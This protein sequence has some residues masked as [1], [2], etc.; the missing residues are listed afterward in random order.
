MPRTVNVHEAKTSLSRLLD[1]VAR[2][3]SV[4]IARAGKPVA[5]L[6]PLRR[7]DIKWG[8]LAGQIECDDEAFRAADADIAALFG[9]E[10]FDGEPDAA[11]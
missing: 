6:V 10:L 7:V 1:E 11:P 8:A 3:E 2:G 5:E 4:I 9:E